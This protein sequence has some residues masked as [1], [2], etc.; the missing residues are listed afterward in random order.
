MMKLYTVRL[1][2][3]NLEVYEYEI[4]TVSALNAVT[5]AVH[6]LRETG[7]ENEIIKMFVTKGEIK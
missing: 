7:N 5:E 1:E 4:C 3:R 2:T 6:N